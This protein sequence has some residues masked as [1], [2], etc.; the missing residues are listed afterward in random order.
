MAKVK[1][2]VV[3]IL[4]QYLQELEKTEIHIKTAIL[5][6]SYAKGTSHKWSDMDVA[7]VSDDFEGFSFRDRQK[8]ARVTLAVDTRI[9]PFPYRVKDFSTDD[10]FVGEILRTGIRIR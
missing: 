4:H 9:S 5:F 1:S 6:G 8:I 2:E 7:L 3:K 10:F